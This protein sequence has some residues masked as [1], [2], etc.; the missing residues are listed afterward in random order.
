[1]GEESKWQLDKG[2]TSRKG[3][4]ELARHKDQKKETIKDTETVNPLGDGPVQ[5][6]AA[7]EREIERERGPI[8]PSQLP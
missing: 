6:S 4:P 2:E 1:M 3:G 8:H 5:L 7:R